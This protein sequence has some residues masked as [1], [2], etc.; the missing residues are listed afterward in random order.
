MNTQKSH[1]PTYKMR[2]D[3]YFTDDSFRCRTLVEVRMDKVE[4]YAKPILNRF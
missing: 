1:F 3:V 4:G 2:S